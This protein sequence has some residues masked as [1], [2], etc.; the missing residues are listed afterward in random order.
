MREYLQ[1]NLLVYVSCNCRVC[2]DCLDVMEVTVWM[3]NLVTLE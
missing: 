3:E 2:L 1:T